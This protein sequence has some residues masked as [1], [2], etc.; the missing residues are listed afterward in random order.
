MPIQAVMRIAGEPTVYARNGKSFETRK[1]QTGLDNN[2]MIH[3]ISGLEEGETVLLTPPLKAGATD[4]KTS[5]ISQ[6]NK[7]TI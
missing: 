1:V 6:N 5:S 2:R 3:I 4:L 7:A